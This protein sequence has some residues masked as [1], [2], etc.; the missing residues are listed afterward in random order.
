[1][2]MEYIMCSMVD[3]LK[4]YYFVRKYMNFNYNCRQ[5]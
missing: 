4:S 2:F 5:L 1:M 3:V